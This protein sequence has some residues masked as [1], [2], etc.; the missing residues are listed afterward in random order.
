MDDNPR[1]FITVSKFRE[2]NWIKLEL[3]YISVRTIP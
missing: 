1:M 3:S 2:N